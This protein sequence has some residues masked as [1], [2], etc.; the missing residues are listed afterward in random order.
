MGILKRLF[1]AR[2]M[3][4]QRHVAERATRVIEH[5]IF[6][7]GVDRLVQGVVQLDGA[8]RPHFFSSAPSMPRGALASVGLGGLAESAA[9]LAAF[10]AHGPDMQALRPQ[11]AL[12][13]D[14]LLREFGVQSARF[15]CL[16]AAR[17][18]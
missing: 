14:G 4:S 18:G 8:C 7:M 12:L 16:P 11:I 17:G 3:H 9:L 5:V 6:D 10:R 15:R 2:G 13:V 1:A